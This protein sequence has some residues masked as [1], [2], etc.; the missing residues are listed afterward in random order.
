MNMDEMF[1]VCASK[2]KPWDIFGGVAPRLT[3]N[4]GCCNHHVIPKTRKG[5]RITM[6]GIK[7][8][9]VLSRVLPAMDP[10]L[11]EKSH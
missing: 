5:R 8:T 2:Q 4:T 6:G 10:D 1:L 9:G 3:K 7:Q 11:I